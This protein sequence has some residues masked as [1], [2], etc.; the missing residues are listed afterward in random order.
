[1][2]N[3]LMSEDGQDLL[4]SSLGLDEPSVLPRVLVPVA[5]C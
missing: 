4:L 1:M 2:P 5:T 3:L